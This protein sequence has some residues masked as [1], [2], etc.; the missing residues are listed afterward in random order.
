[1]IEA[2]PRPA[3]RSGETAPPARVGDPEG[4]SGGNAEVRSGEIG[5]TTHLPCVCHSFVRKRLRYPDDPG[6]T[7]TRGRGNDHGLYSCSEPGWPGGA[8]S[9]R[10]TDKRELPRRGVVTA[11]GRSTG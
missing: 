5:D 10:P 6:T 3:R 7:W 1:G 8:K 4:V 9:T 11:L 2:R